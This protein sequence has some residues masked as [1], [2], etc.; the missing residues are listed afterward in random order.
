MLKGMAN[1]QGW[2]VHKSHQCSEA[3]SGIHIVVV[4]LFPQRNRDE[5]RKSVGRR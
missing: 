2:V 4:I 1:G 5:F 3:E